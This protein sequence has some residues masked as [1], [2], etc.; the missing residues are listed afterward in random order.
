MP[1]MIVLRNHSTRGELCRQLERWHDRR[2][3]RDSVRL[4]LRRKP[5][6]HT[7]VE[8]RA[9]RVRHDVVGICDVCGVLPLAGPRSGARIYDDG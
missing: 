3:E 5:G 4:E 1:S 2:V 6:H 8:A 9:Q 7:D